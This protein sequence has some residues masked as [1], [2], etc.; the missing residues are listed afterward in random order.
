MIPYRREIDGLRAIAVVPVILFHAGMA[1]FSGGFVGVD[2]FFVISGYLITSILIDSLERGSFSIRQFYERRAR[3]ILPALFFVMLC[4]I[5]FAWVWMLPSQFKDFSQAIVAVSLFA[6]NVLFWKET[7]YFAPAAE[8]NPLLHTWSLAVEEQ[9]YIFF[10]LMLF[11]LWR[12]G[13]NRLTWAIAAMALL[14]LLFSEWGWR[15]APGANFFLIPSRAWELF[16]GALAALHLHGRQPRAN[17]ALA[18]IGLALIAFAVLVFDAATPFP[19]LY[20]LAPVAGTVLI[21]LYAGQA[22]HTGR[23]L[24]TTPLVGIGLISYSAYLWHQPLFAFARLRELGHPSLWLMALLALVSL[25][26]GFLTWRYV[27]QPFRRKPVPLLRSRPAVFAAATLGTVLFFVLGLS[28]HL[29]AGLPQ[30]FAAA[31]QDAAYLRSAAPSPMRRPCHAMDTKRWPAAASCRYHEDRVRVAVL[32]DSHVV[33]LAFALAEQMRPYGEG[34]MHFSYSACP[35]AFGSGTPSGCASWT[36]EAVEYISETDELTHVVVTYR[37]IYHLMGE[38]GVLYPAK[39]SLDD[40]AARSSMI[41]SLGRMLDTLAAAGK[42]VIFVEQPPELPAAIEWLVYRGDRIGGDL[43]GVR[44]AW[45]DALTEWLDDRLATNGTIHRVDP[46]KS[47]CR[48]SLCFAGS[49]G[50]SYYFDNNHLSVDGAARIAATVVEALSENG[51]TLHRNGS[52]KQ[53]PFRG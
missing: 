28:G 27:E 16:A 26:L 51:L 2:V 36:N 42:T 1:P 14:S 22:N 40:T 25:A 24:A 6:S 44:R 10:P 35:P 34:I 38:V 11:L 53:L 3:R 37:L 19:S 31:D 45:W 18:A 13:R 33:E 32:G 8:D 15:H 7:D 46:A 41:S 39:P 20:T 29:A 50:T 9:F 49:D 21:I 4:C 17:G 47:L 30:R 52:G 5:P 48:S 12:Y 23:L 43:I